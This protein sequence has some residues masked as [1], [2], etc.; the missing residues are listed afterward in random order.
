[1]N[2]S[3]PDG[4]LRAR[5]Y[6]SYRSTHVAP[7]RASA[8]AELASRAPYL[9]ALVDRHFPENR[10]AEILDLGCGAGLLL[11]VAR[12]RGYARVSGVDRSAE[13][14]AAAAQ[15]GVSN[16]V[17]GDLL[18]TL[19]S[20]PDD[21]RDVVISFDVIEHFTAEELLRFVDEVR[22]VLRPGGRWIIHTINAESPFFGRIRYGDFT[23]QQAFSGSS[24]RQLL[25]A[26]GFSA[27]ECYEDAPVVHGV[28]SLARRIAWSGVRTLLRGYLAIETG[29]LDRGV[30]LSQNFL[31]VAVK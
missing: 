23:H 2:P 4:D 15:L 6:G 27:V 28:A 9:A 30:I 8:E 18:E 21:A 16:I 5:I 10:D 29:S 7:T 22:R 26:S 3:S 13:Q 12:G 17:E 24:M 1:M 31:T 11:H 20:L 14:V 19:A 25:R